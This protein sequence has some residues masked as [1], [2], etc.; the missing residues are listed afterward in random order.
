[1]DNINFIYDAKT[2]TGKFHS[3][4]YLSFKNFSGEKKIIHYLPKDNTQTIQ[5]TIFSPDHKLIRGLAEKNI[6]T[7]K[8]GD[9][10]QFERFGFCR[11]DSIKTENGNKIFNFWFTH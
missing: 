6:E 4:D 3:E 8:V 9:I 2:K 11:L 5:A 7:I 1:M 10:I